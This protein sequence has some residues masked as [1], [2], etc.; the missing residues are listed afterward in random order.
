MNIAT[1]KHVINR[2]VDK[3]GSE[4]EAE[5]RQL[6]SRGEKQRQRTRSNDKKVQ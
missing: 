6:R 5:G 2:P 3:T 1:V 4:N